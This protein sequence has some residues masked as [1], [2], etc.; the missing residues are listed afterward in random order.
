MK[1]GDVKVKCK[2]MEYEGEIKKGDCSNNTEIQISGEERI[3]GQKGRNDIV[4]T[5][6]RI[7]TYTYVPLPRNRIAQ[8]F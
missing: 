3:G 4:R 6:I 2:V 7:H 5:R 1:E 8:A